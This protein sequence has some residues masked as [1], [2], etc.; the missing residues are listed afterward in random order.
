MRGANP[1]RICRSPL[2]RST[3]ID[4]MR[5][6]PTATQPQHNHP[7]CRIQERFRLNHPTS[8]ILES[9]TSS[10]MALA[11]PSTV[12][13][14]SEDSHLHLKVMIWYNMLRQWRK[15]KSP[16][17]GEVSA[18]GEEKSSP[19]TLKTR[20][21]FARPLPYTQPG[22]SL[23]V[24]CNQRTIDFFRRRMHYAHLNWRG[25]N[26]SQARDCLLLNSSSS[27]AFR[28]CERTI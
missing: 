19:L 28:V 27:T 26:S 7:A 10:C 9:T 18:D 25:S 6:Y 17:G 16:A 8:A 24:M 5:P 4:S 23:S 21:C 20:H 12:L 1:P 14:K 22:L 13:S 2:D 3:L 15:P 11:R